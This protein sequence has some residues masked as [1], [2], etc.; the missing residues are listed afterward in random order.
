MLLTRV[1]GLV[2]AALTVVS[3]D[4]AQP[5]RDNGAAAAQ[6]TANWRAAHE[7]RLRAEDGWLSVAG[8]FFLRP[9]ENVV[10]SDAASHIV[11]PAGASPRRLGV[12]TLKE[13]RV[14]FSIDSAAQPMVNGAAAATG[15]LRPGAPGRPADVLRVGRL[16]LNVHRSGGRLAIRLR[17]PDGPVRSTFTGLRW[18]PV[19]PQWRVVGTFVPHAAPRTVPIVNLLGDSLELESPGSVR[20]TIDGQTH[21]MLALEEEGR[22]W[23]VFTDATAGKETYKGAR[24]L[25]AD[26]PRD[27]R[28]IMDFNRAENPPCAYNPFTTCPLPPREN[29][30]PIP[31]PAGERDYPNRWQPR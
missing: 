4:G 5:P 30:L 9:G 8:L 29:R 19:A 2:L 20:V 23:F 28:V 18:F 12:V 31:I 24:Y 14:Y 27:G 11:L 1:G 26:P 7:Q 21:T 22:L 10:G 3:A 17:D 13:G 15:E 16:A 25:Y 6:E